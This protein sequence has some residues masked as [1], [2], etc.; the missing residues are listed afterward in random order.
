MHYVCVENSRVVSILD[1]V[2]NVPESIQVV[3]LTDEDYHLINKDKPTHYFDAKEL[4]IK[5]MPSAVLD[6]Y[7]TEQEDVKNREFLSSTDWKVLRHIREKAL[8]QE[9]S[10]TEEEY[11]QLEHERADA[12]AS[13]SNK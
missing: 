9:T 3:Q 4:C 8:G 5:S 12:A 2:P 10:L 6:K 7:D 11:L 1:Y 13:I